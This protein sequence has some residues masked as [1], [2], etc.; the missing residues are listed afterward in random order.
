MSMK[1]RTRQFW[2]DFLE[3]AGSVLDLS[4]STFWTLRRTPRGNVL[5]T[6]GD[7]IQQDRANIEADFKRA[8][9]RQRQLDASEQ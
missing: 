4:G 6:K 2:L 1:D 3:G 5:I 8:V 7:P 9:L